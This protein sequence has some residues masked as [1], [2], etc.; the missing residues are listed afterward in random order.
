MVRKQRK[1]GGSTWV[2]GIIN[3]GDREFDISL[4][5]VLEMSLLFLEDNTVQ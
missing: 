1:L 5:M 4:E 2:Q 3:R